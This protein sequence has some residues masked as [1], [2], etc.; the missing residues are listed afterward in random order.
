MDIGENLATDRY[1]HNS[2]DD[3]DNIIINWTQI[4]KLI[5]YLLW[6]FFSLK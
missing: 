2:S 6:I 3:F 5:L 1:T 4:V